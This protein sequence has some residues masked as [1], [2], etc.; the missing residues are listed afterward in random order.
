MLFIVLLVVL[1]AVLAGII[2]YA[3]DV[4]GTMIGR[5]RLSLF[6]LR[7]KRSGQII[8]V[9][10]GILIMLITLGTLFLAF[11]GAANV[12]ISAQSTAL[13]LQRLRSEQETLERDIIQLRQQI[14]ARSAELDE[15]RA[16]I[17]NA[18]AQRDEALAER[19]RLAEEAA[20]LET[21]L[22]ELQANY[23]QVSSE[24]EQAQTALSEV[25][26]KLEQTNTQLQQA[27]LEEAAA[28]AAAAQSLTEAAE[29]RIAARDA[30][31]EAA[32]L[33]E[34][35][36]EARAEL[37][38]A[39][40]KLAA[41]QQEANALEASNE[42]LAAENLQLQ[43]SNDLLAEQNE[44]LTENIRARNEEINELNSRVSDLQAELD[45]QAQ[46]LSET[47]RQIER[48]RNEQL[49]YE[50]GEIVH[51]GL[52][53]AQAPAAIEEALI[54]LVQA[55]NQQTLRRGAGTV[56]L[57]TQQL[58]SLKRALAESP[59]ADLVILTSPTNQVSTSEV[60]VAVEALEN[61]QL[62]EQGQ[63]ISSQQLHLGTA[64]VPISQNDLRAQ[65]ARLVADA[66]NTLRRLGL[67]EGV[68]TEFI[69]ISQ[70]AL[71]NQLSRL[72]GPVVVGVVAAEPIYKAGPAALE[73]IIL[74]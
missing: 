11:R 54:A 39:N 59:A 1:L 45:Q 2:A 65:L 10:V 47:E 32:Q 53:E 62:L 4:L 22:S 40:E 44:V 20:E 7:P 29:A 49:T 12:L 50:R 23:Q 19:D 37:E 74:R 34:Q 58:D 72:S 33:A 28:V 66:H 55:A 63:L 68:K 15:A 38:A 31:A 18:E 42:Q 61:R 43:T 8:G 5:R 3:G 70:E 16:T 35:V 69:G 21:N 73:L 13:E 14:E 56:R 67:F 26:A 57:N 71:V 41:L 6:G 30:E 24:L 36:A 52:I 25:Q 27:Q 64:E 9:A 60:L 48:V 17:A 51:F 46:R